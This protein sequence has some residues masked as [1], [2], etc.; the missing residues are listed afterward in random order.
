MHMNDIIPDAEVLLSLGA[1]E[2]AGV[3]LAV[4]NSRIEKGEQ[5][6]FNLGN[7]IGEI[8]Y[9]TNPLYPREQEDEIKVAITEG[10]TWLLREVLIVFGEGI[11]SSQHGWYVVSR[12]GR[13]IKDQKAFDTLRS[14]ARFP[15]DLIHDAIHES[16]WPDV[17]RG[18]FDTAVFKAFRA[19][20]MVVRENCEYGPEDYGA[21]M[22][23]K[24]FHPEKGPLTDP[25]K[26]AGERQALCDLFAGAIGS[27]K[28]P[29]SHRTGTVEEPEEAFEMLILASHLIRIAQERGE[30]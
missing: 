15:R 7:F 5:N 24:A 12:R 10:W 16:V 13:E 4:L 22:M 8:Y 19:V 25:D 28:N 23:R 11:K 27:Y 26:P 1:E 2:I 21:K 3:V 6:Y 17:V 29:T 20:E 14:T 18:D 9:G 30:P